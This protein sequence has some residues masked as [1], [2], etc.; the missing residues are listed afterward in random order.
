[1]HTKNYLTQGVSLDKADKVLIMLHGRGASAEDILT[2]TDEL[3]LKNFAVIAPQAANN[4]WYPYS[5]LSPPELN[6]PWLTSALSLIK[7]IVSDLN[8]RGF[9]NPKIYF[10]G[11]SQGACLTLEFLARNGDEY[12]GAAAFTGGL[13]G[14]KIYKENYK[15]DFNQTKIF[16]GTSD[17]DPHIPVQRV[18]DSAALLERMNAVVIKKIYPGMG[19]TI[20][21]DEISIVNEQILSL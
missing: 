16:L 15:G 6:E 19:H 18:D 13:I 8:E 17:P 21:S 11:F 7:E 1:M 4:T 20:N 5:F 14:D 3:D 10:I 12:G 9:D 2:L